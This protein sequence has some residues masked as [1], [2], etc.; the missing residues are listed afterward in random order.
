MF[1]LLLEKGIFDP[2]RITSSD[3]SVLLAVH[4]LGEVTLK[5]NWREVSLDSYRVVPHR[6]HRLSSPQFLRIFRRYLL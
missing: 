5:L 6:I 1:T 3:N 2:W 4:Y